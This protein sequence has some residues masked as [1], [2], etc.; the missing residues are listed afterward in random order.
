MATSMRNMATGTA[1]ISERTSDQAARLQETAAAVEEIT[2]AAQST[3][4]SAVQAEAMS[5]KAVQVAQRSADSVAELEQV[6]SSIHEASQR[7]GDISGVIE[8]IAF[9]TNI[10]ALNAAVEVAYRRL[11]MQSTTWMGL[12]KPMQELRVKWPLLFRSSKT[13]PKQLLKPSGF[14]AS[15]PKFRKIN[16]MQPLYDASTNRKRCLLRGPRK[17]EIRKGSDWHD[18]GRTLPPALPCQ[19]SI[20]SKTKK[21]AERGARCGLSF[22]S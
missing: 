5:T 8:S 12:R 21:P 22:Y 14:F 20:P 1:E 17:S 11:R 7:V 10:L 18:S 6:M 3:A 19:T 2:H 16:R 15:T 4:E 13:S 9:Q